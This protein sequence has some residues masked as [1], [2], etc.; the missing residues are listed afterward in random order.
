MSDK[1]KGARRRLN[2][3]D[4][5]QA[6]GTPYLDWLG[7]RTDT[8]GHHAQ[9]LIGAIKAVEPHASRHPVPTLEAPGDTRPAPPPVDVKPVPSKAQADEAGPESPDDSAI[10]QFNALID[11]FREAQRTLDVDR[12]EQI[13]RMVNPLHRQ[14]SPALQHQNRATVAEMK[15]WV[16][17]QQPNR[18][19]ALLKLCRRL[20]HQMR[21]EKDVLST[22]A[23]AALAAEAQALS[24]R[25]ALSDAEQKDLARWQQHLRARREAEKFPS[26]G[27]LSEN[28][29]A[30]EGRLSRSQVPQLASAVRTLLEQTAR[31]QSL[32][33]WGELRR[34]LRESVLPHLHPDDQGEILVAVD[35][36]TP[37]NEP[38]LSSLIVVG[39][40]EIHPL[41]RHVA[42]S[43][44][45]DVPLSDAALRS[46]WTVDVLRLRA[47]WKHR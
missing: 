23:L 29:P 47:L 35:R 32:T 27:D 25:V 5:A 11:Q 19:S 39:D 33:T 42:F 31:G 30:A 28:E 2:T 17:V 20:I 46:E 40:G 15:T 10:E 26:V 43:L 3:F 14:L 21:L 18:S 6:K 45:R 44:G 1:I 16:G 24:K 36:D 8:P 37:A 4:A 38:L 12:A 22:N 13:Y 9:L 41:Y 7:G 34:R